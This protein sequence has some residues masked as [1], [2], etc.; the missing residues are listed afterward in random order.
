MFTKELALSVE[1]IEMNDCGGGSDAAA[2]LFVWAVGVPTVTLI[3]SGSVVL[4]GNTLHW[5]EYHG[6]CEGGMVAEHVEMLKV[7]LKKT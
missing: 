6:A 2:C 1:E 5:L 4:V 3:A 7:K